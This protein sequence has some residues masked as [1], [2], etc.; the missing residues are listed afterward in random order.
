[1]DVEHQQETVSGKD[2]PYAMDSGFELRLSRER[3]TAWIASS[4]ERGVV[5]FGK[6]ASSE[7]HQGKLQSNLPVRRGQ[8]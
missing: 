7:N 2:Q 8:S 4:V 5:V 1:M 6:H 3:L